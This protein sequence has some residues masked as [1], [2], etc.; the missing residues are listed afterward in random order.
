MSS[1]NYV[2]HIS[3]IPEG[4]KE[5]DIKNYFKQKLDIEV[6]VG[7]IRQVKN[8]EIPLQWARVDLRTDEAYQKAIEELRFPQFVP[9]ISSRLLPNDRDIISKDIAE[10][11]VFVKGLDKVKYDNDEF[12]ELFKQFGAIDASKVSKTVRKEDNKIVSE[13]NGYGFIKFADKD[14]ARVVLENAK[15]E[16]PRI[17][18]EPYLKERKKP[19]SN[20]LYVKNFPTEFD[21]ERLK[22]LFT[23]YGEITSVKII[24]DEASGKKFGYVCF[25]DQSAADAA[26]E[27]H[28]TPVDENTNLYVQ[29][30]EK[31]SVRREELNKK[32]KKQNL[33][34]TNFGDNVTEE[35][36]QDF[37]SQF[38]KIKNVKILTKKIEVNGDVVEASK[39]KGFVCFEDPVDAKR[40]LEEA[41]TQGIWFDSKRLNVSTFESRQERG[42]NTSNKGSAGGNPEIENFI[43]QFLQT[44]STGGMGAMGGMPMMSNPPMPIGMPQLPNRANYP[45][46]MNMQQRPRNDPIMRGDMYAQRPGPQP[47]PMSNYGGVFPGS[48]MM[49]NPAPM[50]MMAPVG[51]K[52]DFGQKMMPS[53]GMGVMMQA[54]PMPPIT[55]VS[56]D[57]LYQQQY[58][59]LINSIEYQQASDAEKRNK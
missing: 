7:T 10:K 46:K 18:V 17:V 19:V 44:M 49:G 8:T 51:Y 20:N 27:L 36:L 57:S 42:M 54:A 56:E 14:Q 3:E 37:F 21:E 16:D 1:T 33:F 53:A 32:F 11:N 35:I 59:E 30:H 31:K 29:R 13:S 22:D 38:G 4:V 9:G 43:M 48:G 26:L 40:V 15:L 5:A 50:G 28:E 25:K 45:T 58:N 34:V 2:V 12:Y 52:Q 55:A 24:S 39:C 6:R 23:K 41:K 47:N